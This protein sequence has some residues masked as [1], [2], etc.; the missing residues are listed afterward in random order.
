MLVQY[1][2]QHAQYITCIQS[3]AARIGPGIRFFFFGVQISLV[4]GQSASAY[5]TVDLSGKVIVVTG[6]N[7]GLGYATSKALAIMGAHTIIAC[8]SKERAETVSL[9][10]STKL[11]RR[12]NTKFCIGCSSDEGR[13]R[14][15]VP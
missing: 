10:S 3:A 2:G 7:A 8:R 14:K 1:S 5:P 13:N 15:A 6:G 12:S 4:M 9:L 11:I